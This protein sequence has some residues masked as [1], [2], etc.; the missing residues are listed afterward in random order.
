M[1]KTREE[2]VQDMIK[3]IQD[4][5]QDIFLGEVAMPGVDTR[6]TDKRVIKK[7]EEG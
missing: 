5:K 7:E 1:E 6:L 2:L 3:N 4:Q